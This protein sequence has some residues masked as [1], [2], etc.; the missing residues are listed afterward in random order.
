MYLSKLLL[1]PRCRQVQREITRPY[2]MH[3]TLMRAFPDNLK[4]GDERVLFRLDSG[5]N[6]SLI[7]LVQSWGAPDWCQMSQTTPHNYLQELANNPA[8]KP[9]QL[10][11]V[12]GQVLTF[13]LRANPTI[14][15]K[16]PNGQ[17]KRVGIYSQEKQLA[18]L[19]RKGEQGGFQLTTV[20]ITD[21]DNIYA[22]I[23]HNAEKHKLKMNAVHF[24]GQLQVINP[25][26]FHAAVLNGIGSGKGFG[27]GL[28]SLAPA[29]W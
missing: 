23:S 6:G 25:I 4:D 5:R 15:R 18:W 19:Q 17:H 7:L 24:D 3:R 29:S 13:R 22:T 1:N 21:Q 28:L 27:F 11:L 8:V 26:R 10:E 12:T 20:R 9:F 16:F 2:Q 14:K